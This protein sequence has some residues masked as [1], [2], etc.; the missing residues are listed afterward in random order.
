MHCAGPR[1]PESPGGQTDWREEPRV[2]LGCQC[3]YISLIGS[4]PA[5]NILTEILLASDRFQT[6]VT[7]IY[8]FYVCV[9]RSQPTTD[10]NE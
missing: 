4:D 8:I 3:P 6:S 5:G 7:H 2:G 9:S 10:V 1:G